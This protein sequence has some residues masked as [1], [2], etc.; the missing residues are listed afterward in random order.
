[1]KYDI[2]IIW[3]DEN[4]KVI[5]IKQNAEVS[6]Y[7]EVFCPKSDSRYVLELENGSTNRFNIK[8]GDQ[9]TF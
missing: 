9:A 7:P 5:D 3:L 8:L 1:M 4:K 2:D 6:S